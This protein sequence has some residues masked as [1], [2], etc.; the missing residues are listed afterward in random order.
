[1]L[2][3]VGNVAVKA[4]TE[5]SDFTFEEGRCYSKWVI[6]SRIGKFNANTTKMGSPRLTKKEP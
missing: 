4:Q 1:M 3:L 5:G 2:L 6:N